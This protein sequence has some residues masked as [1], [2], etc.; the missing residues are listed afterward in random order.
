MFIYK[1]YKINNI[2][3]IIIKIRFKKFVFSI[4]SSSNFILS[5]ASSI[6]L[7][8][9]RFALPLASEFLRSAIVF[10]SVAFASSKIFVLPEFNISSNFLPTISIGNPKSLLTFLR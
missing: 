1:K 5:L 6:C 9:P 4:S 10:F 8:T 3:Q 7:C 2:P